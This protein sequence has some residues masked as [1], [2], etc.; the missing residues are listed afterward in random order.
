M[1]MANPWNPLSD[2]ELVALRIGN[3]YTAEPSADAEAKVP[4]AVR[5]TP[6]TG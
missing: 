3:D 4:V 5:V 2:A 1:S 6:L